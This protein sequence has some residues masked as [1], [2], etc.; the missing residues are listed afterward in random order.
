MSQIHVDKKTQKEW[1]DWVIPKTGD[2]MQTPSG[3]VIVG[4]VTSCRW[5]SECKSYGNIP[6]WEGGNW[7]VFK[8]IK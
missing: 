7:R 8:V 3:V 2:K 5:S 6:F 4:E 1:N